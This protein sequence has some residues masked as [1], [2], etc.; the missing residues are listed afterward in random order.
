MNH[1]DE[2]MTDVLKSIHPG[3]LMA[4][5]FIIGFSVCMLIANHYLSDALAEWNDIK[6]WCEL[7]YYSENQLGK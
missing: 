5:A 7:N 4:L 6:E 3:L 1:E 2:T